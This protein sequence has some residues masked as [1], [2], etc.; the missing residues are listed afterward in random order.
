MK[1]VERQEWMTKKVHEWACLEKQARLSS[2][3]RFQR[4]GKKMLV[5][6]KAQHPL[7][8]D[9]TPGLEYEKRLEKALE[10][11]NLLKAKDYEVD[12]MTFGGVHEGHKTMTLAEAGANWL[13]DH[14]VD[15]MHISTNPVVFSGNDEDRLAAEAFAKDENYRQLHVV[16]SAGQWDRA[17]LY[18]IYMGWQPEFH[19][20]TFLEADPNHSSVCELWGP[21]AVPAFAEGPEAIAEATEKIRARH[22]AEAIE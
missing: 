22:L 18:F 21:W 12:F 3:I 4:E 16:M 14:G 7:N 15:A 8:E 2:L 10:V 6:I 5:A 20:V 19:P 17:R 1:E 13:A 9:G 11:A